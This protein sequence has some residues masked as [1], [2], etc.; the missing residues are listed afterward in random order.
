M[1]DSKRSDLGKTLTGPVLVIYIYICVCVLP[2]IRQYFTVCH[3]Y[4]A[5]Y[6]VMLFS[7][8]CVLIHRNYSGCTCLSHVVMI[9]ECRVVVSPV[10]NSVSSNEV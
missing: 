9:V 4:T 1:G 3:H 2:I 8:C 7:I 6:I 5:I 10:D